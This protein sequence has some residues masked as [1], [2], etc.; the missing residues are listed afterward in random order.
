[1]KKI[2]LMYNYAQHYRTNIFMLMDQQL[3]CDFVF[4]D[5]YLD[6]KKMDYSNLKHFKKE[7][8][9]VTVHYPIYYQKGV[10]PLLRNGYTHFIMLGES[11]C[12]ST[13]MMFLLSRFYK[14]KTNLLF[15]PIYFQF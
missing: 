4:G 10:L 2:C 5:K 11:I 15:N 14:R 3:S 6:V 1:M 8:K 7:V 13:W 9:N 12:I